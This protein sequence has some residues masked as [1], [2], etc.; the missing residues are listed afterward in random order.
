[1]ALSYVGAGTLATGTTTITPDFNAGTAA[2]DTV[3]GVAECTGNRAYTVPAGWAHVTGS[4]NN[5]TTLTRLT[6]LFRIIQ[7]GDTALAWALPSGD[8]AIGQTFTFRGGRTSGNPWDAA[9]S[10]SQDTAAQ[11]TATWPAVNTVSAGTIV[12][13][14]IATGRD[15]NSTANLGALSGGA[16]LSNITERTDNWILTGGGGGI[17]VVT[18]DK[19]GSGLTG[20]PTATMGS[21][22]AKALMTLVLAPPQPSGDPFSYVAG[23]RGSGTFY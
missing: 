19:V 5:V 7:A 1:M 21:T 13:F 17:G 10:T 15:A 23:M 9:P 20:S 6:V 18:A 12:L 16:G 11:T 2:G 22:D 14:I 4:P 3:I 8:H